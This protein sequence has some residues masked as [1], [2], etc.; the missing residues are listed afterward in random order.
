MKTVYKVFL[1]ISLITLLQGCVAPM[2]VYPTTIA[3]TPAVVNNYG[4]TQPVPM[5]V[6]RGYSPAYNYYNPVIGGPVY[7]GGY[8]YNYGYP[9]TVGIGLNFNFNE[10][11]GNYGGGHHNGGH[12]SGHVGGGFPIV[13]K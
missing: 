6:N 2:P 3:S 10:G 11:H 13:K 5:V 7:Y 4:Y 12:S 8:G 9:A 1:V